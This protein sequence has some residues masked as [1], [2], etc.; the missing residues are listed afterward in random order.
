[1]S[2][3]A[4]ELLVLEQTR[5]KRADSGNRTPT[6]SAMSARLGVGSWIIL[7]VLL[8][9]L[10]ATGVVIYRGWTLA[11]G[12]DV[13]ASGYAA[14]VFG[15]IISLAV[16]FG[17]MALIFYSSRKGYDEPPVL[18]APEADSVESKNVPETK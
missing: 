18:I 13:P 7:I 3:T 15:V 17:L 10:I 4:S 5:M 1:M 2:K 16:G 11:G 6:E 14:M 9:L 8:S 12:T